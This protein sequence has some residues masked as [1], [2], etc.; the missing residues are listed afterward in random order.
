M[1]IFDKIFGRKKVESP[2]ALSTRE[3]QAERLKLVMHSIGKTQENLSSEFIERRHLSGLSLAGVSAVPAKISSTLTKRSLKNL[4][5]WWHSEPVQRNYRDEELT[6]DRRIGVSEKYLIETQTRDITLLDQNAIKIKRKIYF[7]KKERIH[8]K[9][10][11]VEDDAGRVY[12]Y[13]D[14]PKHLMPLYGLEYSTIQTDTNILVVEGYPAADALIERG[15]AAVGILSGAFDIPSERT[16]DPLLKAATISLWPDND[17]AGAALMTGVAKTLSRMGA[18]EGQIKL[19]IWREGPKKGD[20]Y[21]FKG[22]NEELKKLIDESMIWSPEFRAAKNI[23][24]SVSAP[25]TPAKL[26]LDL[27]VRPPTPEITRQNVR[28]S[29]ETKSADVARKVVESEP[30]SH[31]DP[32]LF[33]SI[34]HP[35]QLDWEDIQ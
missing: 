3:I 14:I 15:F 13:N 11:F 29:V 7:D 9:E 20:A 17:S 2:R 19:I 21:D 30:M 31:E 12:N 8:S 4:S 33:R 25:Q 35:D 27:R 28:S 16:L 1:R 26:S 24:V 22:S 34:I 32:E 10:L 18:R 6:T 5:P 23:V